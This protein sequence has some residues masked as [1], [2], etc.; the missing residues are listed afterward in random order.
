KSPGSK[1]AAALGSLLKIL[2]YE[3]KGENQVSKNTN[4]AKVVVIRASIGGSAQKVDLLLTG[5]HNLNVNSLKGNDELLMRVEGNA[6][7]AEKY[8]DFYD[9]IVNDAILA[10][11]KL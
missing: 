9:Q 2:P 5:S 11:F 10:G 3:G 4:H 8:F 6:E 7:I 1:V